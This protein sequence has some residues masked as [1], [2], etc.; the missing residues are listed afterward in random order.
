[1]HIKPLIAAVA[2]TCAFC[3]A[4]AEP[5]PDTVL[6]RKG[7]ITVTAGDF[8]AA[9][10]KLPEEQRSTFRAEVPRISSAVSSLFVLR[11]LAGEARAQGIDKEP[12][13]QRRLRLQEESLLAGVY[14]ERLEKAIVTPDFE[15]R[16]RE[17]YKGSPE[18]FAVPA[19]VHLRHLVV[20]F[21]GRTE[22]EA[23][24]RAEEA[25]AKLIAGETFGRI[26]REYSNDPL[27]R[28]NDGVIE[29]PYNALLETVAAAAR[30]VPLNQPSELIRTSQGYHVIVVSERLPATTIPYEKA[31]AGLIEAEKSKFR[32]AAVG[33]K[34][35]SI[36]QSK[37]VTLYTDEIA[38]LAT[39]IDRDEL[40]RLHAEQAQR[41]RERK[42]RLIKE[43][44][45][46]AGS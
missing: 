23:R 28:S 14:M 21:Q 19:T 12:E 24:R 20:S 6:V 13:I 4:A 41:E 37:E 43:S 17:I 44:A 7:D 32:K 25:R 40:L 33:E 42:E 10:E 46:P 38:A 2:A 26:V 5:A 15:A 16:V 1:M 29:G 9:L 45:K 18:R 35:A 27:V 39:Y 30:T 31:R 8:L 22:E 36:T 11:T 34:L 3:V